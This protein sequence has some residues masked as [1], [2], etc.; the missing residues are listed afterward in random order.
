MRII[1]RLV[2]AVVALL[3]V[4][5][6]FELIA[7]E[8]GEVVVVQTLDAAGAAHETR[9]WVVDEGDRAWIR[10][11]NPQSTWLI[12]IQQNPAVTV[13]RAGSAGNYTAV[14]D[15]ASRARINDLMRAKY[16]WADAYI[17]AL[18]GR[19][20]ATPIR[21]DPEPQPSKISTTPPTIAAIAGIWRA[22]PRSWNH[23][24][25]ITIEIGASS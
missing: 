20:D 15:V 4:V 16:G 6:A 18:F 23:S 10:A 21:L 7:S 24:A 8:S 9:L 3:A 13:T 14:P 12:N 17:G 11:G 19:D 1:V 2:L 22:S 5:V 25:E